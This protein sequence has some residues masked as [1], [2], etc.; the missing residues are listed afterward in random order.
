MLRR[1]FLKGVLAGFTALLF[2][3]RK[4]SG[5]KTTKNMALFTCMTAGFQYHKGPDIIKWLEPGTRLQL[6]READNIHDNLAVAIYTSN[7]KKLGYIPR[8]IN[9]VPAAHLDN[10][11]KI[12]AIVHNTAPDMPP[13]EML[14]I[15][16]MIQL[17]EG[18]G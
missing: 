3:P 2:S 7:G 5:R 10:G 1:Q 12:Y 13:W 8:T 4:G 18:I 15:V 11:S 6:L 14:E 17:K 9:E 16:V